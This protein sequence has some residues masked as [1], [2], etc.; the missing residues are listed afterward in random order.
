LRGGR[1]GEKQTCGTNRIGRYLHTKLL[2]PILQNEFGTL[3]FQAENQTK[4][5]GGETRA[6]GRK[7]QREGGGG[8]NRNFYVKK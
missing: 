1:K 3:P 2:T 6:G 4:K 8:E 7:L 5:K